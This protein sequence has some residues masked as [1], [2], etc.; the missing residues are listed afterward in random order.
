MN[1]SEETRR[2]L[3]EKLKRLKALKTLDDLLRNSE[4][5]EQDIEKMAV[6]LK[7]EAWQRHAGH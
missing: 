3:Q 5:T 6:Q 7:K 2:F 4:L 1:W